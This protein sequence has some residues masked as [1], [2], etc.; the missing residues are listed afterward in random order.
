MRGFQLSLQ[1]LHLGFK[2]AI[3]AEKLLDSFARIADEKTD[4]PF[5]NRPSVI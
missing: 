2:I 5:P 4:G 3:L 1:K